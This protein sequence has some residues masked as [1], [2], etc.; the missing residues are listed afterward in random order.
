[1]NNGNWRIDGLESRRSTESGL[2]ETQG[3]GLDWLFKGPHSS[4]NKDNVRD[5]I[6]RN[7][8]AW[9]CT[10]LPRSHPLELHDFEADD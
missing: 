10:A 3:C 9:D 2:D 1:M 4:C 6:L 7:T 5:L 8:G